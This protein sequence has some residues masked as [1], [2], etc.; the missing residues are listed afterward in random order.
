MLTIQ[1]EL[2]RLLCSEPLGTWLC[3]GYD[4]G[5][6]NGSGLTSSAKTDSALF[7][8]NVED[9]EVLD[10]NLAGLCILSYWSIFRLLLRATDVIVSP[11]GTTIPTEP[12]S[13]YHSLLQ[14]TRQ[15]TP[16]G[17]HVIP[18]SYQNGA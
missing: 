9:A 2:T 6:L 11:P 14:H 3:P 1:H 8:R 12:L 17:K 18:L 4:L 10:E 7:A 16:G 13:A 5:R 15:G